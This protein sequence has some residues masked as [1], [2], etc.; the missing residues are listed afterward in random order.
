MLLCPS[1]CLDTRLI[2]QGRKSQTADSVPVKLRTLHPDEH[3]QLSGISFS[4]R[5][6]LRLDEF[7]QSS[8]CFFPVFSLVRCNNRTQCIVIT[9]SDVF[10]D[11]CPGTYKY[12]EVQY[13]CVPYSK[14]GPS[15]MNCKLSLFALPTPLPHRFPPSSLPSV[16]PPVVP[17]SVPFLPD[18]LL[19]LSATPSNTLFLL[20]FFHLCHCE[21]F[22]KY[23]L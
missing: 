7:E 15:V 11:P 9:G 8:E 19:S 20:L 17:Y 10:P 23:D 18:S 13:E 22:M 4:C 3:S 1:V 6:C 16:S 14:Y 2:T 5:V 21:L 12:L